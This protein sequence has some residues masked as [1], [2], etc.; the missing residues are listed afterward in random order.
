MTQTRQF[1]Y[2]LQLVPSLLI[3]E[4]WTS[5]E[6]KLVD[7]HFKRLQYLL[8][9]GKLI[10]AGKTDGMDES[11]F[12]IVI[13]EVETRQEAE[14]IMLSDPAVDGGLM[15]AKLFPFKTALIRQL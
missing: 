13:L 3:E 12:G 7:D 9:T 10:L 4:N 8:N 2:V 6:E 1:I 14:Q 5:H 15:T 11:T